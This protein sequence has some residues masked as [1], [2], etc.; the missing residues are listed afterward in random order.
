[1]GIIEGMIKGFINGILLIV[2]V[3]CCVIFG[4]FLYGLLMT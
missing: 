1:M 2:G 3:V 4:F